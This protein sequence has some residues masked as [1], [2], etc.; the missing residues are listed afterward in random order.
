MNNHYHV[1]CSHNL[2][3]FGYV[4]VFNTRDSLQVGG[5]SIH[6]ELFGFGILS[7]C[8]YQF[9]LTDYDVNAEALVIAPVKR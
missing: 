9:V 8:S 5:H 1:I 2:M 6:L 3:D 4:L 7:W